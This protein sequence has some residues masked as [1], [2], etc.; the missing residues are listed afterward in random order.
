MTSHVIEPATLIVPGLNSSGPLHWQTWFEQQIAGAIRVIQSDWK[1][2]DLP[3]WASRVRRGISRQPGRVLIVA[4]SFGA[5]A[6]V[7]A[8]EDHRH[9]IAGALLVAPADPE[10]F[11]IA[12]LLPQRALGFPATLVASTNDPWIGIDRAAHLAAT[13]NA[14]FVNVGDAGHINSESGFGPWPGG[15][16]LLQRLVPANSAPSGHATIREPRPSGAIGFPDFGGRS[17]GPIGERYNA[18]PTSMAEGLRV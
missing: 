16:R 12:D 5:L 6:A 11:G 8:A 1:R 15:L 14:D 18:V 13:W 10:K 4:H 7:Q 2:A 9:R 3:E 17:G